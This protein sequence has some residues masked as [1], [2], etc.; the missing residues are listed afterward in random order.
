[1]LGDRVFATWSGS[2][3]ELPIVDPKWPGQRHPVLEEPLASPGDACAMAVLGDEH[4]LVG[5]GHRLRVYDASA[6][7]QL[8]E[9][10]SAGDDAWGNIRAL[11]AVGDVAYVAEAPRLADPEYVGGG[12]RVVDL[13]DPTAPVD[14]GLVPRV[15]DPRA[16]A[17]DASVAVVAYEDGLT[18]Y[19][20]VRSA[21]IVRSAGIVGSA[22]G[23]GA[24]PTG[25]EPLR[26]ANDT[27]GA[28][29]QTDLPRERGTLLLPRQA[30]IY[31]VAVRDGHAL[32]ASGTCDTSWDAVVGRGGLDIFDLNSLEHVSYIS[33]AS[34]FSLAV[35]GDIAH[36]ATQCGGSS[37]PVT[38]IDVSEPAAPQPLGR[39]E[40]RGGEIHLLAVDGRIVTIWHLSPTWSADP[41]QWTGQRRDELLVYSV[42][43]ARR[44]FVP[45]VQKG[46][47]R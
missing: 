37:Q 16:I 44:L 28:S 19:D 23:D 8:L 21:Y 1:V 38:A 25:H 34:A 29:A 4:L 24:L 35:D 22:G 5:D 42:S 18:V 45:A 43:R 14:I 40:D 20:I 30:D 12:L 7:G 10:G 46:N 13:S 6:P 32:V 15:G 36:V 9:I 31:D 41:A 26:A 27:A 2:V 3:Y 11:V 33:T 39:L 47:V 17:A